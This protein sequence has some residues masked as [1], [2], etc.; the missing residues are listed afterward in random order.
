MSDG[1]F[2]DDLNEKMLDEEFR[3]AYL[4]ASEEIKELDGIANAT[5][6]YFPSSPR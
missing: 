5:E 2:W 6:E 4:R 1:V 3:Q